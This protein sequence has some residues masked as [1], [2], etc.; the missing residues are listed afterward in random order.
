MYQ[1]LSRSGANDPGTATSVCERP[2]VYLDIL[3]LFLALLPP[4]G[5]NSWSDD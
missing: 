3:N 4:F 1:P 2:A 5:A